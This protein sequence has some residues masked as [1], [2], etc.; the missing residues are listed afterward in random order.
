MN[1]AEGICDAFRYLLTNYKEVFAIG[2]GL[3]SPWYVGATMTDLDKEFGTDRVIDT[4]VSELA[5]TG[6]AVQLSASSVTT[7]MS[8][9]GTSARHSTVTAAGLDAVGSVVSST[10]MDKSDLARS[11]VQGRGEAGCGHVGFYG[12]AG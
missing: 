6:A 9:A 2:Q 11:R 8:A 7:V 5:T 4:P 1:Y 12:A 3:W 10:T